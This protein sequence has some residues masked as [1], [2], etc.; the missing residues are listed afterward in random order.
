[1]TDA[2]TSAFLGAGWSFPVALDGDGRIALAAYEDKVA[3]SI[4]IILGTSPGERPMRPDFGC[5]IQALVFATADS[6]AAGRA[7]DAVRE[8]LVRWEPR[9][10]VLGVS[11]GTRPDQPS[12]LVVEVDY[13][14]RATNNV[15]NLVYPFYL[16][17]P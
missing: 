1:M 7:A 11:A 8:A 2:G 14:V 17:G 12:T 5:P 9:I 15:F 3:Q 6:T 10:D 13:R 16:E 4:W